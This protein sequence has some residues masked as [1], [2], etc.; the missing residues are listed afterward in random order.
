MKKILNNKGITLIALVITI[1]ILLILASVSINILLGTDGLINKAKIAKERHGVETY[2]EKIEILKAELYAEKLKAFTIDELIDKIIEKNIVSGGTIEKIDKISANVTTKEG[3][4]FVITAY[5]LESE[6][7]EIKLEPGL[8]DA[9]GVMIVSWEDSGMNVEIDYGHMSNEKTAPYYLLKNVYTT[10]KKIVIPEGTTK[11][12]EN[13]FYM[14]G[15][16]TSVEIPDGVTSIGSEAFFSCV[17]LTNMNIPDSVTSIG[18]YAFATC[19]YLTSIKIPDSVTSIGEEAFRSCASLTNIT[20]GENN[21]EY[22]SIDGVLFDKEITT[23]IQYPTGKTDA[24]YTIPNT[25]KI[26]KASSFAN[27]LNITN[28]E[29]PDG[30]TSIG[31]MTFYNCVNLKS[32]YIPI[33]VTT[34]SSSTRHKG[35]FNACSTTLKIYCG[36]S[37]K[38]SGWGEYWNHYAGYDTLFVAYGITR[39]EYETTYKS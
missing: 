31:N 33:S 21:L 9:D 8:Y 38:Q 7:E 20:V 14:C 34:I 28:I 23:L 30:V 18:D 1:I 37:G 32:I 16:L 10:T 25:V 11:I 36:A 4:N 26:I 13:M 17:G 15:D 24:T 12:G 2:K 35:A 5:D 3:Y 19:N 27:C 29:I 22:C 39:E 6:D